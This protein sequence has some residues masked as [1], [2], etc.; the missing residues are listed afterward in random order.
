MVAVQGS[1]KSIRDITDA[2]KDLMTPEEYTKYYEV[3][4]V[5]D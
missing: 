5:L 1:M 4:Q 3:L 2:D